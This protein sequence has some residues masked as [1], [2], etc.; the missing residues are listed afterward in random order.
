MIPDGYHRCDPLK[1]F[2]GSTAEH[3]DAHRHLLDDH[4]RV[5]MTMGA[6][7]AELPGGQRVLFDLGFG[8]R[9]IILDE[10][11]LEFWGGRLLSSLASSRRRPPTTSTWSSYSH[12]HTDH[13]GW[14]IDQTAAPLTFGNARHV[15]HRTEW[16]HWTSRAAAAGPSEHDIATARAARRARRRRIDGRARRQRSCRRPAT[17]PD[18]VRFSSRREPSA[19]SCS[20][21]PST[22][23]CRSRI[24][25]GRSRQD[26]NPGRRAAR[27]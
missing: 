15:M 3:W 11:A 5:V 27:P 17:L 4:G 12:L 20:A 10:L 16:E 21:T 14:T 26:G 25:S 23:R 9:T 8:A 2:V 6:L 18:T 22:A 19:R 24:P 1:T 7:L 13:V